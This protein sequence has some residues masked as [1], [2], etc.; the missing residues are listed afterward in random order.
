[1]PKEAVKKVSKA[2]FIKNSRMESRSRNRKE[3]GEVGRDV[4]EMA[5]AALT[6]KLVGQRGGKGCRMSGQGRVGRGTGKTV[7][8]RG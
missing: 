2:E 5:E 1:M 6:E 8:V 4:A 3:N 7:E